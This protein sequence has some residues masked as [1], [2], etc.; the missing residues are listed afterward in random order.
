MTTLHAEVDEFLWQVDVGGPE[1]PQKIADEAFDKVSIL[2]LRMSR[3]LRQRSISGRPAPSC[4]GWEGLCNNQPA[5]RSASAL[6]ASRTA[7]P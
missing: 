6:L 2:H 3:Q 5:P 4:H 7:P 1:L